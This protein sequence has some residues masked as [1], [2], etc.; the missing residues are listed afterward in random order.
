M[1][2]NFKN[3]G[4]EQN[5]KNYF[6]QYF[7]NGEAK[8]EQDKLDLVANN[9]TFESKYKDKSVSILEMY[10]Q[11]IATHKKH[12]IPFKNILGFLM[13]MKYPLWNQKILK[14]EL[15]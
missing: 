4:S 5:L 10:A 12:N 7:F 15:I 6:N 1:M 3:A 14:K 13:K 11:L 9:I 8:M 2:E